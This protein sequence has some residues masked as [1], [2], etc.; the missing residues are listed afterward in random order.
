MVYDQ[1][2][3]SCDVTDI[4]ENSSKFADNISYWSIVGCVWE[5]E[6]EGGGEDYNATREIRGGLF[7][8]WLLNVPATG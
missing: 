3:R 6:G 2:G 1:Y 7:V 4:M 5:E 8:G